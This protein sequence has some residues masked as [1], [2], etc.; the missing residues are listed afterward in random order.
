MSRLS[1]TEVLGVLH[2]LGGGPLSIGLDRVFW[3]IS[4]QQKDYS[5]ISNVFKFRLPSART[6]SAGLVWP[7]GRWIHTF[8]WCPVSVAACSEAEM[9]P[10]A[11]R[12]FAKYS[13]ALQSIATP[14]GASKRNTAQNH[15]RVDCDSQSRRVT[16]K[17]GDIG[18]E[19]HPT[20]RYLT[21][22]QARSWSLSTSGC[23]IVLSTRQDTPSLQAF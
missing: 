3:D 10:N 23:G 21:C 11:L 4:V 14:R 15:A 9:N 13:G 1:L 5:H 17:K 2:G 16:T 20:R 18:F 7:V 6:R 19:N 22:T 8:S 12:C